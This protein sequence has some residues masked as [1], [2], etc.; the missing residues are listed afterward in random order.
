M[1]NKDNKVSP[2]EEVLNANSKEGAVEVEITEDVEEK[3]NTEVEDEVLEDISDENFEETET[4]DEEELNDSKDETKKTKKVKRNKLK[5]ENAKLIEENKSLN[6]RYLKAYAEMENSKKRI[7]Q[8]YII[9]RKYSSQNILSELIA[10]IDM[11][12]KSTSYEVKTDEM[13]NFLFGFK[14]IANQ[15][16]DVLKSEGLSIIETKG[17]EF[18]PKFHHA[19]EKEHVEGTEANIVL[20]ETQTGYMYKDRVLR[21]AM[22]KVSE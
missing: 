3:I 2:E 22:V 6:E 13:R 8:Q 16:T 7:S 21:P 11:L 12:V 20:E 9:D 5:D 15:I 14:M 4:D 18:D 19:V 10:P 17:K 1:E